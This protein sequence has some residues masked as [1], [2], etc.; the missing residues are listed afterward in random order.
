MTARSPHFGIGA[1]VASNHGALLKKD[2]R[3]IT[4]AV[5]EIAAL[6]RGAAKQS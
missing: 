2:F 3:A 1:K 5:R 6:D 4:G